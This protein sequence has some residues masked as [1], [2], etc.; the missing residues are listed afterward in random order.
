MRNN[1]RIYK[2]KS[3]ILRNKFKISYGNDLTAVKSLKSQYVSICR[4][5]IK[6]TSN[7][8][9]RS[10]GTS[11]MMNRPHQFKTNIRKNVYVIKQHHVPILRT[12]H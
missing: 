7:I 8:S 5:L 4:L 10:N 2:I 11:M 6:K 12:Y 3:N 9:P 1:Y